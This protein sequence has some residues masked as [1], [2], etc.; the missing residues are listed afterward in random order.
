MVGA[1]YISTPS[2]FQEKLNTISR[3]MSV[4]ALPHGVNQ[5]SRQGVV[6]RQNKEMNLAFVSQLAYRSWKRNSWCLQLVPSLVGEGWKWMEE[7]RWARR[8]E[9]TGY[10]VLAT[11]CAQPG[12]C[13]LA[14]S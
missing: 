2:V 7:F 5:I 3:R 13:K 9:S 10:I 4:D 1:D 11:T 12:Q 6:D 8:V 14:I